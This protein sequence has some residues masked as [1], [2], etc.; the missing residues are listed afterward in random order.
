MP[1]RILREGIIESERVNALSC[2]AEILYRRLMSKVDDYGRFHA[3]PALILA[4]CYPLQL[5]RVSPSHVSQWLAE[6][7]QLPADVSDSLPLVTLYEANGK[8]YLQINGFHQRTR[9]ESRF[10]PPIVREARSNDGQVTDICTLARAGV[11]KTAA[12]AKTAAE[13]YS[14]SKTDKT[15]AAAAIGTNGHRGSN[16]RLAAAAVQSVFNR[17]ED[18]LIE[19]LASLGQQTLKKVGSDPALLTDQVLADAIV[20]AHF[21]GQKSAKGYFKTLPVVIRN[22]AKPKGEKHA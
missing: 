10:P 2:G 20:A 13:T 21:E 3:N 7:G 8:R 9:S 17:A 4:A 19:E 11:E 1:N 12:E 6:C 22:W 14:D 5:D 16:W 18:S 15:A